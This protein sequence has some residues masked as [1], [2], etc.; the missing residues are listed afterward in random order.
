MLKSRVLVIAH[1]CSTLP[2]VFYCGRAGGDDRR[3]AGGA[4]PQSTL[5]MSTKDE[6]PRKEDV[7]WN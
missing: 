7:R 4:T 5:L 1:L 3:E 2:L 6:Q